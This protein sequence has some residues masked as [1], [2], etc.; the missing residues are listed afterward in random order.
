MLNKYYSSKTQQLRKK[1]ALGSLAAS[2]NEDT[3]KLELTN[4]RFPSCSRIHFDYPDAPP[5]VAA[6]GVTKGE[7]KEFIKRV[8]KHAAKYPREGTAIWT[9]LLF[10]VAL[11]VFA[12][13]PC[14]GGCEPHSKAQKDANKKWGLVGSA[15]TVFCFVFV[16]WKSCRMSA[17]N[18][19]L[20][21]LLKNYT[22][23]TSGVRAGLKKATAMAPR[24]KAY[25]IASAAYANQVG[26]KRDD[27]HLDKRE[28][29]CDMKNIRGPCIPA[30]PAEVWV[31]SKKPAVVVEIDEA[32]VIAAPPSS[33]AAAVV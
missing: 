28:S 16:Y 25:D 9:V 6:C 29:C 4:P 33:S 22:W 26:T 13:S 12:L 24:T 5:A 20:D 7:W 19:A 27:L 11:V 30:Q 14:S 15:I 10:V 17:A 32:P 31:M 21:K 23:K 8:N 1:Q 3:T 2:D 18:A